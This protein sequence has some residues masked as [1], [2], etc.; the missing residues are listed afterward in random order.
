MYLWDA[1]GRT[2]G[3]VDAAGVW[4]SV[5]EDPSAAQVRPMAAYVPEGR[6]SSRRGQL[7]LNGD[8]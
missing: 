4:H 6:M 8:E 5:A 7:S 3:Y 1:Q 2:L